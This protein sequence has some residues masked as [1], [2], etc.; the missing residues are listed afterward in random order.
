[1]RWHPVKIRK[2]WNLIHVHIYALGTS[3]WSYKNFYQN[4]RFQS[5]LI[6]EVCVHQ[7]G[8]QDNEDVKGI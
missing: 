7:S 5:I 1:M 6:C 8:S 3:A 4:V 2:C